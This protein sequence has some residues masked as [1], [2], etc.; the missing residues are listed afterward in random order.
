MADEV[1]ILKDFRDN[2]LLTHAIGKV[3]VSLYYDTSPS[4]ADFIKKHESLKIATRWALTPF[5][6]SIKYPVAAVLMCA[7][8]ISVVLY[9]RRLLSNFI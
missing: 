8:L 4:I 7:F 5:V 6:Y 1:N 9:R 2:V 3:F